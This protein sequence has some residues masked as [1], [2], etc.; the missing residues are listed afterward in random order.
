MKYYAVRKGI[1]TGIFKSWEDCKK[2][3][4][5]FPDAEYKSF[6]KE[7]E[8]INYINRIASNN[9]SPFSKNGTAYVD[10]SFN[11]ITN[12]YSFGA[13]LFYDNK[14]LIFKKKFNDEFSQYR[15][16][17]GEVRG[18]SF[19]I[20]KAIKLGLKEI[21]LFYDYKGI[22]EWYVGNWKANNDLTKK[23]QNFSKECSGKIIVNF[24]KVESH[25]G[26]KYNEEVDILAKEALG[27]K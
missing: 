27:I 25:T 20:Y 18:S 12:E 17:S 22:E 8:A 21:D 10:G 14:K 4:I 6:N 2:N 11:K 9:V 26:V 13:I 24:H 5:G 16:V 15:N 1:N 23:Y 3:V 7:E 19:I